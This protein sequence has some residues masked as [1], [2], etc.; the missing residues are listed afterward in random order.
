MYFFCSLL[1]FHSWL[2]FSKRHPSSRDL[3]KP[4]VA[5]NNQDK[6]NRNRSCLCR[7]CIQKNCQVLEKQNK[8]K[9]G[10]KKYQ[11]PVS[12][13]T[14][15]DHCDSVQGTAAQ[16]H[17]SPMRWHERPTLRSSLTIFRTASWR[18]RPRWSNRQSCCSG[19]RW[20]IQKT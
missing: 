10:E 14:P 4:T 19:S 15:T 2:G 12:T 7:A 3:I 5:E 11:I 18:P 16:E 6:S 9:L 8:K 20:S 1:S 13:K 17:S